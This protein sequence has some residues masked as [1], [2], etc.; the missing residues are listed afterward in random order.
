ME[1]SPLIRLPSKKIRDVREERFGRLI[2]KDFSHISTDRSKSAYWLC[3]CDCGTFTKVSSSALR[4][5]GEWF[6][7][8]DHLIKSLTSGKADVN[9]DQVSGLDSKGRSSK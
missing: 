7:L 6:T 3:L 4:D 8:S 1:R 9:A 2:V 5:K